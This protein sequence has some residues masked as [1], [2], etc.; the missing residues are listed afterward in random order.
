VVTTCNFN[1]LFP[2]SKNSKF[3]KNQFNIDKVRN[4]TISKFYNFEMYKMYVGE[5]T[6]PTKICFFVKSRNFDITLIFLKLWIFTYLDMVFP[7]IVLVLDFDEVSKE[8]LHG[9][10]KT[11]FKF[12]FRF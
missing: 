11:I 1:L 8:V 10:W 3:E 2:F 9:H 6:L 5:Q 7:V 12:A 4:F